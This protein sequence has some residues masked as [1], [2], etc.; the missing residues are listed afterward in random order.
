MKKFDKK[1]YEKKN[2]FIQKMKM[3]KFFLFLLIKEKL[4]NLEI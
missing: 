3:K 4:E 1:F 2:L